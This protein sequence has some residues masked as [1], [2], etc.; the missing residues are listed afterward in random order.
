MSHVKF[1]WISAILELG[2]LP[3]GRND[4][5]HVLT[6]RE[7]EHA[8]QLQT[9]AEASRSD[10]RH[11]SILIIIENEQRWARHCPRYPLMKH[12]CFTPLDVHLGFYQYKL[13]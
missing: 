6:A 10:R 11:D 7:P 5:L 13:V 4:A 9:M 1:Q 3:G 2:N 12:C 8:H